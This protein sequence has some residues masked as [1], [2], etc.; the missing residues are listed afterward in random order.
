MAVSNAKQLFLR[1]TGGGATTV[2]LEMRLQRLVALKLQFALR[3][4]TCNYKPYRA[5]TI[6]SE[7][8]WTPNHL[9]RR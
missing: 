6:S 2:W 5:P 1:T 4:F 7:G 9:L 8:G 3:F